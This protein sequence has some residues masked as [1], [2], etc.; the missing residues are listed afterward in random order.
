MFFAVFAGTMYGI[1]LKKIVHKYSAITIVRYQNFLAS[2]YFLPLFLSLEFKHFISVPI[3][4]Q[5]VDYQLRLFIQ[6]SY[7]FLPQ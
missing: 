2:L 7:R 1:F 5:A 6:I 3:T 4:W